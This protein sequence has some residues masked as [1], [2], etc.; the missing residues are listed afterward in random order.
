MKIR[1]FVQPLEDLAPLQYQEGYDNSGWITGDP[2]QE[3]SGVLLTLDVTE[4]VVQEAIRSGCNLIIAHHPV[5]FKGLKKITGKTWVERVILTAIR[6]KIGIY[7]AHT[8]LDN[9][10]GGVNS[11]ICDKLELTGRRILQPLEG[12]RKLY[13]FVPA[14]HAENLRNALF[15]AGAGKIGAYGECS[16]N[17][18]GS[19]TFT[20][21]MGTHPYIGK[22]GERHT[23]TETRIEMVFS[24]HLQ[25]EVIGALLATHP[26]EVPAYDIVPLVNPHP[27]TG[28]GMIGKL[29]T[30]M[31]EKE[32]LDYL[33]ERMET[34][35]IRHTALRG[36]HVSSV[37]VCGGAGSFLLGSALSVKADAFVSSDFKYH[38]FFDTENQL[39][40]AD[41]GHYESERFTVD[42]FFQVLTA[43]YPNFAPLKSAINTNPINYLF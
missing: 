12:L 18:E 26:Y 19:G 20:P 42:L 2:E 1:E 40:I 16:F 4:A 6:E 32:F 9:Q 43:K 41:I 36:R 21:G 29:A 33:K 10:I 17:V 15:S 34:S 30:P 28:A 5:I 7:A 3:A 14:A 23:E 27:G 24:G 35:C 8:N 39:I 31:D 25:Q 22:T 13:T 11:V 38:E 37:A